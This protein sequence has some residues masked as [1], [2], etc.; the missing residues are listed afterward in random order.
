[1]KSA[2]KNYLGILRKRTWIHAFALT[3]ELSKIHTW[4]ILLRL[5]FGVSTFRFN[6]CWEN[7]LFPFHRLQGTEE[8]EEIEFYQ[9]IF[10]TIFCNNNVWIKNIKT[11]QD[12]FGASVKVFLRNSM[13]GRLQL[14]VLNNGVLTNLINTTF[15]CEPNKAFLLF[16]HTLTT[17]KL[18]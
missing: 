15:I 5:I 7:V 12:V 14:F 6:T 3:V 4:F 8:F 10:G 1:M 16:S 11:L 13:N 2:V 9:L 17:L 18:Y